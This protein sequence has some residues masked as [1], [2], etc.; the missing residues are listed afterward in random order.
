MK[1][2]VIQHEPNEPHP[3]HEPPTA[4]GQVGSDHPRRNV[5]QRM[6]HWSAA[7]PEEGDLRLVRFRDRPVR[8][9]HRLADGDDRHRHC[10]TRGVWAGR[11]DRLRGLRAAR[12]RERAGPERVAHSGHAGVPGGCAGCG[13]RGA[14]AGRGVE[15]RVADRQRGRR[16]G[17]RGRAV[18]A[19]GPGVRRT[20]GRGRGQERRRG[21]GCGRG[22]GGT[23]RV[24][25]RFVRRE[26]QQG[27]AGLVLRRPEDGGALLR[28]V[29]AGDL[30]GRLWCAVAAGIPLLL[31]LS[32]VARSASS[33]S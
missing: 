28:A 30:V 20:V 14:T 25:R 31:G 5:A 29:D 24:L 3:P 33:R 12:D 11:H 1:T 10:W 27:G 18:G 7:S 8:V 2:R 4:V 6:A 26:H 13:W 23:S 21:G 32:A 22:A 19:G 16:P 15:C 17:F 9:Q